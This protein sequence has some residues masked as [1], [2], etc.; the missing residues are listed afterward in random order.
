MQV[1]LHDYA[2]PRNQLEARYPL[3]LYSAVSVRV[4][5]A[6]WSRS[7]VL[8]SGHLVQH[9][10]QLN[11]PA[12]SNV[13]TEIALITLGCVEPSAACM[14]MAKQPGREAISTLSIAFGCLA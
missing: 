9:P 13:T 11:C 12:S 1:H 14:V 8:S 5:Q 10:L 6:V 3:Q 4:F 7:S 2:S